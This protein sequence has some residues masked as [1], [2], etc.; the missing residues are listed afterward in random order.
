MTALK[1]CDHKM[2]GFPL[3]YSSL[4]NRLGREN[5]EDGMEA[6]LSFIHFI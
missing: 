1:E 5:R 2:P 6:M 3:I 4:Q